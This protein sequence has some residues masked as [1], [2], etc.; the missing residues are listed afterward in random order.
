[1]VSCEKEPTL[2]EMH[3]LLNAALVDNSKLNIT[4]KQ[5][6]WTSTLKGG[7]T[8]YKSGI[9]IFPSIPGIYDMSELPNGANLISRSVKNF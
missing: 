9:N 1:M 8:Y 2:D 7:S 4:N 6:Y 3:K 5:Y